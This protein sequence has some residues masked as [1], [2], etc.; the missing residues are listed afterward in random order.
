MKKLLVI[1]T[2]IV[3]SCCDKSSPDKVAYLNIIVRSDTLFIRNI[4]RIYAVGSDSNSTRFLTIANRFNGFGKNSLLQYQ[5]PISY[6][7]DSTVYIFEQKNKANDTIM[8]FYQRNLDYSGGS[9]GY[10]QTLSSKQKKHYSSLKEYILT[11]S[12]G[13]FGNK[14]FFSE[15]KQPA[16]EITL[17]EN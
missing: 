9:C 17:T 16:C 13:T 14:T 15:N 4:K 5:L 7:T 10:Q 1:L 2:I 8:I 3:S 6:A 12:F 11:T